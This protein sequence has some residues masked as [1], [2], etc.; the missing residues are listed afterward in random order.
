MVFHDA[1]LLVHDPHDAKH[2]RR[3]RHVGNDH[4]HV[5]WSEHHRPWALDTLRG[6]C[7]TVQIVVVPVGNSLFHVRVL[8]KLSAHGTSSERTVCCLRSHL[9]FLL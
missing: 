9:Y 5:V 4:V 8:E 6:D 3:K 2:V 1:S 7:G